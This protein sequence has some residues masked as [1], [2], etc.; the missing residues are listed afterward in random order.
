MIKQATERVLHSYSRTRT[1]LYHPITV[2]QNSYRTFVTEIALEISKLF[3]DRQ[4]INLREHMP[5]YG[6]V[7]VHVCVPGHD[8]THQIDRH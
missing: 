8:N 4:T 5:V 2:A 1:H 3:N 6:D 7:H